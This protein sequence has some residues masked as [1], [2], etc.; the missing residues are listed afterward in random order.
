M[1]KTNRWVTGFA[2]TLLLATT[3]ACGSGAGGAASA[4]SNCTPAHAV[5]TISSGVLTVS[6]IDAPPVSIRSEGRFDGIEP[7]VVKRFATENCLTLKIETMDFAAA[8]QS[9]KS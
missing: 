5:K 6:A 9:V 1:F 7:T 8:L 3:A 4:Q 2:A